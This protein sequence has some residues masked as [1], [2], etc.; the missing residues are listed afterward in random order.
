MAQHRII[1]DVAQ[2]RADWDR[3]YSGY[4]T[5]YKV[6][7][8]PEMRDRVWNWIMEGRINCLMALDADG[9]PV[10]IAHVREFLRPLM[11]TVGGYLDDLFVDPG[12]RGAGV[13]DDL[14]EAVR[15][16]G[17]EKGWSLIRWITREDNY[18]ARAVYDKLA[19]R[20]N[21]TTYDMAL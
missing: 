1:T 20:T 2:Y 19:T 16:L 14:F 10:G 12:Q 11:S 7:Q 3:L 17:R 18:R 21:W 5:Y 8:T 13:V 6:E 15:K 9:K 4:A